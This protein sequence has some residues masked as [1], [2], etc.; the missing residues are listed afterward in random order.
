MEYLLVYKWKLTL[1]T[2]S[3]VEIWLRMSLNDLHYVSIL[4]PSSL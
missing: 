3:F 1:I 4:W 2:L